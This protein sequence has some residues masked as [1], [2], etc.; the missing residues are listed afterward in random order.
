MRSRLIFFF[1]QIILCV[2]ID[3]SV[4]KYRGQKRETDLLELEVPGVGAG[5][6]TWASVTAVLALN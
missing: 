4:G 3:P 6:Q 5:N 1:F 2:Y